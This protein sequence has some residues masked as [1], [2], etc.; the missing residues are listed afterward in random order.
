MLKIENTEVM[1]WEHAIRG[2]RNPKNSW[3]KSDSGRCHKDLVRDCVTCVHHN[4]GYAACAAGGFDVGQNDFDLMTRL[5][6]A[7]TDHRKFMRMITVYLDIT[8]PLYWWKEFDTYKVGTV[9]NSCSTMHKIAAKEFTL[10]DFSHE[11]LSD[12]SSHPENVQDPLTILSS[13]IKTLNSCRECYIKEKDNFF[14]WQMIQL[15]PSSYNQKRTVMLNYE[16]LANIY[17]S[18]RHHKLDEW[19]TLCDRIESLPYSALITG[20]AV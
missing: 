13:T 1:G 6:N 2:M 3:E 18:R 10:D 8:A 19:H 7:G 11:H 16:V 12:F 9:A 17:K 14:W 15:L 4:S 20:T 5:R